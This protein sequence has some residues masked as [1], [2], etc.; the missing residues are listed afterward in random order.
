METRKGV[1]PLVLATGLSLA[2]E[3]AEARHHHRPD[4]AR[5][6][7][8]EE[9]SKKPENARNHAAIKRFLEDKIQDLDADSLDNFA[10]ANYQGWSRA[11]EKKRIIKKIQTATLKEI[12]RF[13]QGLPDQKFSVKQIIDLIGKIREKLDKKEALSDTEIATLGG[14]DVLENTLIQEE[15][16]SDST[17]YL[18]LETDTSDPVSHDSLSTTRQEVRI[19]SLEAKVELRTILINNPDSLNKLL[20]DP[21]LSSLPQNTRETIV[22]EALNKEVDDFTS[23]LK[24]T[25]TRNE[26]LHL[27]GTRLETFRHTLERS[28]PYPTIA[29]HTKQNHPPKQGSV[30]VPPET[31]WEKTPDLRST[32]TSDQLVRLTLLDYLHKQTLLTWSDRTK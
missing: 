29:S 3:N 11:T 32:I 30:I 31:K 26:I 18:G 5:T 7:H 24:G 28:T 19:D 25:K 8:I 13:I 21:R 12:Q 2:G 1:I 6:H 17:H 20:K 15:H 22:T 16:E 4:R 9:S 23:E 10:K 27:L 14:I